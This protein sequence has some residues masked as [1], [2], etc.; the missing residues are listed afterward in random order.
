M[1]TPSSHPN[2]SEDP[3]GKG[4]GSEIKSSTALAPLHEEESSVRW[5]TPDLTTSLG[6]QSAQSDSSNTLSDIDQSL[7]LTGSVLAN[8]YK[9]LGL[10]GEGAM[11]VVYYVR[12]LKTGKLYA[13][14][15][16]KFV[17]EELVARFAREVKIYEQLKHANIVDAL[18]CVPGPGKT[19]ISI[20]ELIEG[21][22]LE[23]LLEDRG[24]IQDPEV[25][26]SIL[27]QLCDGLEYAHERG[28]IHRDLKPDNIIIRSDVEGTSIK[29]LDFGLAKL[30]QDLQRLTKSGVVLGSPAYM[31]P[32]QCMGDPLDIRSDIYSLGVLAFE[33]L[34]GKLPYEEKTPV[35][36]M[37]AHCDPDRLPL[38]LSSANITSLS[39]LPFQRILSKMLEFEPADRYEDLNELKRD[40]HQWWQQYV[41]RPTGSRPYFTHVNLPKL[42]TPVPDLDQEIS[43]EE[44]I[45]LESLVNRQINTRLQSAKDKFQPKRLP[46][47]SFNPRTFMPLA[48]GFA[49][50]IIVSAVLLIANAI[51]STRVN[52]RHETTINQ[53]KQVKKQTLEE[54]Q[55]PTE[56][57]GNRR[58]IVGPVERF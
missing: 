25:F 41:N 51:N 21:D 57:Q 54:T 40:L 19:W 15:T 49:A 47:R 1:K 13:A 24:P 6:S 52:S 58:K 48:F 46:K 31:S 28:V 5:S 12:E 16:L 43:L 37:R 10:L 35:A 23:K 32:E 20:M 33:M 22:S 26:S 29:I 50:L 17:E 36:M 56:R 8:K 2:S 44:K 27:S 42:K 38:T 55:K 18:E 7:V 53:T 4:R 11:A 14:K 9:V 34:T 3:R 39:M 45:E 30:Q